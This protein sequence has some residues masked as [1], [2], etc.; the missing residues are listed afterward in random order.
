[1]ASP[2]VKRFAKKLSEVI[3]KNELV[4]LGKIA[5]DVGYSVSTSK[6]PQL[7]TKTKTYKDLTRPL[8]D[9]LHE[10]IKKYQS[11]LNDNDLDNFDIRSKAYVY[12]ILVKNYQ[13]LSG[14]ATE[15][16]VFVL[17]SQVI[18]KNNIVIDNDSKL[19][20]SDTNKT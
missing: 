8:L 15:R 9:G 13:L 2:N 5:R 11:S 10:Q 14:G 18:D 6:T 16:Q 3:G 19:L 7:I 17:P 20:S 12:D 4:D 1:M